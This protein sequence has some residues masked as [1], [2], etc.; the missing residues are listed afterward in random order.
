MDDIQKSLT[1]ANLNYVFNK[2]PP[3][4]KEEY[5]KWIDEAKK[6][7]TRAKRILKMIDMLKQK[8]D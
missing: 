8:S 1:Q 5:I 3:S 6:P 7:E 2:L 4:H